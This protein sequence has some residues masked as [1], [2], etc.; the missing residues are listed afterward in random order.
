M[1][2]EAT[3]KQPDAA[4]LLV[5]RAMALEYAL[6]SAHAGRTKIRGELN[7]LRSTSSSSFLASPGAWEK[8]PVANLRWVWHGLRQTRLPTTQCIEFLQRDDALH[9]ISLLFMYLRALETIVPRLEQT[10]PQLLIVWSRVLRS[11]CPRPTNHSKIW[12][13]RPIP[14]GQDVFATPSDTFQM[15][16]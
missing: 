9:I 4:H 10:R 6:H 1:I 15:L 14:R 2:R 8:M 12:L 13:L 7:Q 3:A 16:L 5:Q 11:S